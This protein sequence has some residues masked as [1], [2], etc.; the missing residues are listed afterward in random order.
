MPK[1]KRASPD[2]LWWV[3]HP[4]HVLAVVSAVSWEQAT[5]EAAAWWDVPWKEVAALCEC[6]RTEE[7]RRNVCVQCGQIFHGQGLR[8]TRCEVAERDR[9]LNRRARARRYYREAMPG[10]KSGAR[11]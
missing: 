6:E 2:R 5:V 3:R 1:T 4:D 10:K 8:C 11:S 9:E 7:V